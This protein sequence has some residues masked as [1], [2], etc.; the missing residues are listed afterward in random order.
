MGVGL[1]IADWGATLIKYLPDYITLYHNPKSLMSQISTR[2]G[3]YSGEEIR[4]KMQTQGNTGVGYSGSGGSLPVAGTPKYIDVKYG[5][6]YIVASA[7]IGDDAM[8]V[9]K[10]GGAIVNGVKDLMRSTL[11]MVSMLEDY[12]IARD[13]TGVLTTLAAPLSGATI[14][15]NDPRMMVPDGHYEIRAATAHDGYSV[16]DVIT[17][18]TVTSKQTYVSAVAGVFTINATV[19]NMNQ[20]A[21][22]YIV[23][24]NGNTSTYGRAVTGFKKL[25]DDS[26]A[27]TFQGVTMASNPAFTSI[28]MDNGGATQNITL[29]LVRRMLAS[30]AQRRGL[31]QVS[32]MMVWMDPWSN[33]NWE[34]L[35]QGEIRVQPTDTI[36][37]RKVQRFQSVFGEFNVMNHALAPYGEMTFLDRGAVEKLT[38]QELD[39]RPASDAGGIFARSSDNL[40]YEASMLGIYDLGIHERHWCGRIENIANTPL[41]SY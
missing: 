15:V 20:A 14:G 34:E 11:D 5:R 41:I 28:V 23:W 38:Q 31:G 12:L 3:T 40:R 8:S 30:L 37:G 27:G 35:G 10:N 25:I 24:G 22:D 26:P 16:G 36:A 39:W 6:R 29:G 17:T 4:K 9:D 33:V 21:G 18:F 7:S 2:K 32:E 19:A 1:N 13:G